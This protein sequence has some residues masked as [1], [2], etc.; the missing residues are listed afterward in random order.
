MRNGAHEKAIEIELVPISENQFRG[1]GFGSPIKFN[2]D[3]LGKV[4]SSVQKGL[5]PLPYTKINTTN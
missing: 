5:I 2:Q 4:T 3:S 1:S